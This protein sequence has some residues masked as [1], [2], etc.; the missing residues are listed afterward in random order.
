MRM[1]KRGENPTLNASLLLQNFAEAHS[2]LNGFIPYSAATVPQ[3]ESNVKHFLAIKLKKRPEGLLAASIQWT[4]CQVR[5]LIN[6]VMTGE[7]SS[8]PVGEQPC[9]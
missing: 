6:S 4:F 3:P 9:R 7:L 2:N 5:G 1:Q 8:T